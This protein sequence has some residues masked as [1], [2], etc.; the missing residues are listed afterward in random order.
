MKKVSMILMS[1]L[2]ICALMPVVASGTD[3]SVAAQQS[4]SQQSAAGDHT[5]VIFDIQGNHL[6]SKAA[7]VEGLAAYRKRPVTTAR[8]F[9]IRQAVIQ[10]YQTKGFAHVAVSVPAI[11]ASG[12]HVSLK[13]FEDDINAK[14]VKQASASAGQNAAMQLQ[15]HVTAVSAADSPQDTTSSKKAS[16]SAPEWVSAGWQLFAQHRV[17]DAIARWQSGVNALPADHLLAYVNVY[18]QRSAAERELLRIGQGEQMLMLRGDF[19]GKEAFYL[20]SARD[21]PKEKSERR[22]KL[23]SLW[24]AMGSPAMIYANAASRFQHGIAPAAVKA[25]AGASAVAVA[26]A[27]TAVAEAPGNHV[28]QQDAAVEKDKASAAVQSA[29]EPEVR[30]IRQVPTTPAEVV[31]AGSSDWVEAGWRYLADNNIDAALASWQAGVDQLSPDRLLAFLGVY[32]QRSAALKRLRQGGLAERLI[33]VQATLKDRKA[34]YVLSAR[35][36]PGDKSVRREKLASLYSAMNISGMLYANAARKFQRTVASGAIATAGEGQHF[37]ISGFEII[38]NTLVTTEKIQNRLKGYRGS[39]KSRADLKAAKDDIIA[40]YHDAGYQMISVGL[41]R[42]VKGGMI[43]IRVFEVEIGKIWVSGETKRSIKSIRKSLPELERGKTVRVGELD[44]QLKQ[45]SLKK[46]VRS[47]NLIYHPNDDGVVDVEIQVD[48]DH[49]MKFGAMVSSLGTQ[50]TGR[51]LFTGI[52]HHNDLWSEGHELTVSYSSSERL[53]KLHLL[54]ARYVVPVQT[55]DGKLILKYSRADVAS[56]QVLGV[57]DTR[58]DGTLKSV[59]YEQTL[60]RTDSARHYLD[61]GFEQHLFHDRF[62]NPLLPVSFTVGTL[63]N[64]VVLGYG[65]EHSSDLGDLAMRLRYYHNTPFGTQRRLATYQLINPASVANWSYYRLRATY[66]HDWDH[67]WTFYAKIGGQ[68]TNNTLIGGERY[69][70]TGMSKVRGFE[71]AEAFGDSAFFVRS[72]LRSP[73][74]LPD[75]RFHLF[76]DAGR[77]RLNFPLLNEFATDKIVSAGIGAHWAP[78]FG[79]DASLEAGWVLNGLPVAPVGSLVGHFKFIYWFR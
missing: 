12:T 50:E 27:T 63:S 32:A 28:V 58:G 38:G 49:P 15:P 68:L 7:I 60:L 51:T 3:S 56:G 79:L 16:S 26:S 9:R 73:Y 59:H 6:L 39:Q 61:L 19:H 70:I 55:L 53:Q 47:A 45:M 54:T 10:L 23:A 76:V 25:A 46:N 77:Y 57:L 5:P 69:Y 21:V 67:D 1:L 8:L 65:F 31:D 72:E 43:P 22:Q 4:A 62:V 40:L 41:P 64:P 71:E 52:F 14:P 20:F 2:A 42:K 66:K 13:I 37:P 34:Y 11:D 33:I 44:K 30:P 78:S 17:D 18:K 24:Q 29:A 75:T 35:D 48:E 74:W 36:V